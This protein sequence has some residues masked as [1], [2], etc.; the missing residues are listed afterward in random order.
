[1]NVALIGSGGREH[2]LAYKIKQSERL[3]KLYRLNKRL[4]PTKASKPAKEFVNKMLDAMSDDLNI[5]ITL[6]SID[7]MV[8]EINEKLDINPKDKNLKKES[9]A[10]I[11]FIDTLLGFGNKEPFGYFQIGIEKDLKEKINHQSI[12][13]I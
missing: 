13:Y 1:M 7:E 2:A 4:L 5:S 12:L 9:L 11:E 10:N 3:D 6:A 8:S